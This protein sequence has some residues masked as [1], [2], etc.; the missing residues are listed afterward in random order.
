MSNSFVQ[1]F[2]FS[3][4]PIRGAFVVLDDVWQAILNQNTYPDSIAQVLGELVIANVLMTTGIKLKGKIIAQIQ[5][6][7]LFNLIVSECQDNMSVRATAKLAK[8][9]D[10]ELSYGKCLSVGKLV[11]SIDSNNDGN[12]Y[13]SI[14]ALNGDNLSETINRYMAQSEQL[15]S[16][17]VLAYSKNKIAGFMI[18]QLPEQNADLINEIERIFFLANTLDSDE[19]LENNVVTLLNRLFNEDDIVLFDQVIVNK[20]CTCSRLKVSK[21]LR[22]IGITEIE[23]I[24]AEDGAINV[25]CEFCHSEYSFNSADV[26]DVFV[27]EVAIPSPSD[28]ILRTTQTFI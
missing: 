17:F 9:M 27:T 14:I 19:L 22:S 16:L 11:V 13:Q 20:F 2:M 23:R 21:M 1:K 25:K 15:N 18:Q 12:I 4:L 28:K 7:P 26:V 10:T 8:N 24:I 5:D 3:K 6:S